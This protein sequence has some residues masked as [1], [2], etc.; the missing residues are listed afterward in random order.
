MML[1]PIAYIV[2]LF[3]AAIALVIKSTGTEIPKAVELFDATLVWSNGLIDVLLFILT[4]PSAIAFFGRSSEDETRAQQVA[5]RRT[6]S[7]GGSI[8]SMGQTSVLNIQ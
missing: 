7:Q 2:L 4:R 1:Y 8:S 6:S 5:L 3:P